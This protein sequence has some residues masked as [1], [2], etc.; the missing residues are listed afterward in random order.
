MVQWRRGSRGGIEGGEVEGKGGKKNRNL[1]RGTKKE[2]WSLSEWKGKETSRW[3]E[4]E[5]GGEE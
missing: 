1:G 2:K 4:G 3:G 5:R